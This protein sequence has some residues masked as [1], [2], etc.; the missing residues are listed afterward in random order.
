MRYDEFVLVRISGPDWPTSDRACALPDENA[1][2]TALNAQEGLSRWNDELFCT[3]LQSVV[4]DPTFRTRFLARVDR[5]RPEMSV[6]I[7]GGVTIK[8]P[9]D[10]AEKKPLA[11]FPL[12]LGTNIAE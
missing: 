8:G 3:E 9:I 1:V 12:I 2:D 6:F 10:P 4:D 5:Q 11:I 7:E